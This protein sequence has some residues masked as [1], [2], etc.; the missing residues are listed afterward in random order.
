MT[1]RK[2]EILKAVRKGNKLE[3]KPFVEIENAPMYDK[4]LYVYSFSQFHKHCVLRPKETGEYFLPADYKTYGKVLIVGDRTSIVRATMENFSQVEDLSEA[5]RI[6]N[7]EETI[8]RIEDEMRNSNIFSDVW[9]E[10]IHWLNV[11]CERNIHFRLLLH[12]RVL[13]EKREFFQMFMFRYF[14]DESE[15]I[16]TLAEKKLRNQKL[17]KYQ[18]FR[19]ESDILEEISTDIKC[20]NIAKF[21]RRFKLNL[22]FLEIDNFTENPIYQKSKD[23][24]Y[25]QDIIEEW[26]DYI[27]YHTL[28]RAEATEEFCLGKFKEFVNKIKDFYSGGSTFWT[29]KKID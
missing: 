13:S 22:N 26:S 5:D 28:E 25:L 14:L 24:G 4:E 29:T 23:M 20:D 17:F 27:K 12:L 2:F 16:K 6:K 21:F 8:A 9:D 15:S 10:S 19:P 11:A 1:E 7:K 3:V 18:C